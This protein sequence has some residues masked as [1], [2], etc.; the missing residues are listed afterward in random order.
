MQISDSQDPSS[1][2]RR[3]LLITGNPSSGN[4][5]SA[6]L[7]AMGHTCC[8][9]SNWNA[10]T[11]MLERETFDAVLLDLLHPPIPAEEAIVKIKEIVPTLAHRLLVIGGSAMEPKTS[12]LIGR[13]DL[14]LVSQDDLVLQ[15]WTVLQEI[16]V[17]PDLRTLPSRYVQPARMIFDSFGSP[18]PAGVR[19]LRTSVRQ[20]VYEHE[21]MTIDIS[22]E[23]AQDSRRLLLT[24][25]VLSAQ[26]DDGPQADLPVLLI[27]GMRT[28][29]R[30][31]TDGFGEFNLDFEP[32]VD[33]SLE[34]RLLE[35]LWV[36]IPL[37]NMER[38]GGLPTFKGAG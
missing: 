8:T 14:S 35:R 12:E 4:V 1:K 26:P 15:L 24:G 17:Q 18:P 22:M 31:T 37:R 2:R 20:F 16:T 29:M 23:T 28:L 10:L 25:Q 38:E 7:V 21:N 13:H 36:S 5:I 19:S 6:F 27:S 32:T 9:A 34:I 3:V 33:A 30:T 11:M